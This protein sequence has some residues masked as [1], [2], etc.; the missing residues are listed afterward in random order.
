MGLLGLRIHLVISPIPKCVIRINLLGNW[1]GST[2]GPWSVRT[3]RGRLSG[4]LQNYSPSMLAKIAS[5]EQLLHPRSM[6]EVNVILKGLK[7]AGV[8]VPIRSPLNSPE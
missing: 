7:E 2:L 6:V 5:Q 3:N 4:N 1:H 8:V